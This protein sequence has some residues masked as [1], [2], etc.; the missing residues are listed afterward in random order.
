MF[1]VW[2]GNAVTGVLI[3]R[4]RSLDE[5]IDYVHITGVG[6]Y[7]IYETSGAHRHWGAVTWNLDGTFT[8]K[9]DRVVRLDSW[10]RCASPRWVR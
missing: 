10:P 3:G 6:R 1:T 5:V 4:A 7:E 8:L 2:R 9:P